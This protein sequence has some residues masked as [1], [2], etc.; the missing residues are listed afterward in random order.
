MYET[1]HIRDEGALFHFSIGASVE[2]AHNVFFGVSASH[3]TSAY[4]SDVELSASDVQ[5]LY[6]EGVLT[7][8]GD[9]QTDGFAGADYRIAR[10][11]QYSGSEFRFGVLYKWE[12]FIGITASYKLPASHKVDEASVISGASQFAANRSFAV[13]ETEFRSFYSFTPPPEAGFGAMINLWMLTGTAE[14][15]YVDYASMKISTGVG[16]VSDRTRISKRIKDELTGTVNLNAGVELRVPSTGLSARAGAM[17]QPSPYKDE[18]SR[19]DQKF[20]TAGFGIR[21]IDFFQLDVGYAYGWRGENK[22]Q[23]T[24]SASAAEQSISYHTILF[25]MRFAP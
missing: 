12:N 15:R 18:P 21:S 5:D 16:T 17:Y 19:N 10:E 6:P 4:V 14:A 8:P 11:L 20:L 13:P 2:A 25:T 23:Q 3:N 24:G 1:G 22:N 9:L 7:I